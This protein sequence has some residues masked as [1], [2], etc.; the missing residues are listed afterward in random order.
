[1]GLTLIKYASDDEVLLGTIVIQEMQFFKSLSV[2]A[3]FLP[4]QEDL[5]II[6]SELF[7][8]HITYFTIFSEKPGK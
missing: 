4:F 7:S 8:Q 1:M 2:T 6:R 3:E 5:F